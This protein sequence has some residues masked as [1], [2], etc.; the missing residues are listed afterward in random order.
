MRNPIRTI[1]SSMLTTGL[2]IALTVVTVGL[3]QTTPKALQSD[4]YTTAREQGGVVLGS[5]AVEFLLG[6]VPVVAAV[7]EDVLL[8]GEAGVPAFAAW[9]PAESG[10]A[11]HGESSITGE[12]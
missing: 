2:L 6:F 3:A 4:N 11:G 9:V 1:L 7:G 12:S 8:A 10:L 5:D